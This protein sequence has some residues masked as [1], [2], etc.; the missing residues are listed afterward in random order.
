MVSQE[1]LLRC[2]FFALF[3]DSQ[4]KALGQITQEIRCK[5]GTTFFEAGESADALYLLLD[6]RV[7][8]YFITLTETTMELLIGELDPGEPFAISALI[9]PHILQHT[10]RANKACHALKIAAAPLRSL[11]E[12]ETRLGYLLLLRIA[13]AAMERLNF[14]RVQI[15]AAQAQ[16]H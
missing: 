5:A 13:E 10:V 15:A 16:T 7:D 6:G 12:H 11:C 9:P 3:D 14:T 1:L 8:L 2:P 4:R